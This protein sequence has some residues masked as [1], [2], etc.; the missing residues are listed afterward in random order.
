MSGR[1]RVQIAM[2]Y[3]VI[4]TLRFWCVQGRDGRRCKT[5]AE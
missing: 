2:T 3:E 5:V 1:Q 4:F